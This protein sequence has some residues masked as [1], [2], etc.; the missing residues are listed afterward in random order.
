MRPVVR[1]TVF[2]IAGTTRWG[3][4]QDPTAYY[5]EL[6]PV[7]DKPVIRFAIEEALRAGIVRFLFVT[8]AEKSMV[9]QQIR[10][11]WSRIEQEARE[12]DAAAQPIEA[13][14]LQQPDRRGL[15]H[16][17]LTAREHLQGDDDFAV[18][19]PNLLILGEGA[20]LKKMVSG[21]REGTILIGYTERPK[22]K[23]RNFGVLDLDPASGTTVRAVHEKP[24]HFDHLAPAAAFGRWICNRAILSKLENFA[25][26][27]AGEISLTEAINA[28]IPSAPVLAVPVG[29][30]CFDLRQPDGFVQATIAY[31][32]QRPELSAAISNAQG[33]FL[34]AGVTTLRSAAWSQRYESL[35][36]LALLA[37][38]IE[39]DFKDRIALVSSFGAESVVL[40]HMLSRVA[41]DTPVLFLETGKLFPETLAYQRMLTKLLELTEVRLVRPDPVS[42]HAFDRGGDLYRTNADACCH[43]RKTQPLKAALKPYEAWITGRKRFQSETRADLAVFEED[44]DGRLKVNPLQDWT[45]QDLAS[46]MERHAVPEHPLRALGYPSVGC[47]P[48]TTPVAEGEDERA[49]RWR[50]ASKTECGI[51][52]VNGRLTRVPS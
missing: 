4:Q 20:G 16:A 15:G 5:S 25:S 11:I 47:A 26:N 50:G 13:I 40:L 14:F 21:H 32:M 19:I 12:T 3:E 42:L 30:L 41:K 51:H 39:K 48:C 37:Q 7:V 44:E 1:S 33:S 8:S 35:T 10:E 2:P 6:R 23:L 17:L 22:D 9:E 31:A 46:Y 45:R 43:L 18:L 24:S 38:L 49:G 34:N 28:I 52:I 36:P 29:G 27:E